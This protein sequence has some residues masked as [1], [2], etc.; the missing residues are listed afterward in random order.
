MHPSI[1]SLFNNVCKLYIYL[2]Y[3]AIY[4]QL[5]GNDGTCG[6]KVEVENLAECDR[7]VQ[8]IS[9]YSGVQKHTQVWHGHASWI[10]HGC[11]IQYHQGKFMRVFNYANGRNNGH[12]KKVCNSK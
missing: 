12:Y 3:A 11:G 7:A 2:R 9:D 5:S 8:M 10:F 1:S 6:R 4:E